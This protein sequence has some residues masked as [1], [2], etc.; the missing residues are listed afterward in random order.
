MTPSPRV[1]HALALVTS[2]DRIT[3]IMAEL[4]LDDDQWHAFAR[5]LDGVRVTELVWRE[6][7]S[8]SGRGGGAPQLGVRRGGRPVAS[9]RRAG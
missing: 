7:P 3:R 5:H 4:A 8:H 2:L 9:A 1:R 6:A